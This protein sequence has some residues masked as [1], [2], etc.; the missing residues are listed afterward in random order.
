MG[1]STFFFCTIIFLQLGWIEG[2]EGN[3]LIAEPIMSSRDEREL[4][5]QLAFERFGVSS[6]FAADQAV[7][8]L[9]SIGKVSGIVVDVGLEKI[10]K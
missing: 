2:E 9:Y 8:S 10:G 7:L 4:L 5:A 6:Y 3:L 1:P